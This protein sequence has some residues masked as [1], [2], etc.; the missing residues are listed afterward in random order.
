MF[1]IS[2]CRYS[3]Y[4]LVDVRTTDL[5]MFVLP[6]CRCSYYRTVDV[7]TTDLQMF[8]LPNCRCSYY[9]PKCSYC[10]P[11]DVRTLRKGL[12][13]PPVGGLVLAPAHDTAGPTAPSP[14]GSSP[15]RPSASSPRNQGYIFYP[16][17]DL[18]PNT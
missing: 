6:T 16:I 13:S 14:P 15:C 7:R 10:L 4:R 17:I 12:I 8:V 9:R 1:V 5:F 2:A 11:V 3:Y 18:F